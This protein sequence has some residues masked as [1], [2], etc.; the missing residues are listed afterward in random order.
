MASLSVFLSFGEAFK[1]K[2]INIRPPAKDK[3]GVRERLA[4]VFFGRRNGSVADNNR[5][6]RVHIVY[7]DADLMHM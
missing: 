6:L 4:K 3:R 5:H 1:R 7:E 2:K